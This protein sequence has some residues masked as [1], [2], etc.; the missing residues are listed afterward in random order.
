[1]KELFTM[2]VLT[3]AM[4]LVACSGNN[5]NNTE[6]NLNFDKT[7]PEIVVNTLAEKF[8]SG[9]D[10]AFTA[11]L[12]TV[13]N[14]LRAIIKKGDVEKACA[15]AK[16]IKDFLELNN[17]SDWLTITINDII[18]IDKLCREQ[19]I[20]QRAGYIFLNLPDHKNIDDV[21]KSVFSSSF[22]EV[23]EKAFAYE[24]K[25]EEEGYLDLEDVYYWYM[26]QDIMSDDGLQSISLQSADDKSAIVKVMY[27]NYDI[28]EHEMRLV[29]SDNQWYCDNWDDMKERLQEGMKDYE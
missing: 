7:T 24:K 14:E 29:Y 2:A 5:A 12:E 15:Y 3:A 22:G 25:L 11:A 1:M 18:A 28:S 17:Y 27:K 20:L 9:N 21:D 16:P 19:Q 13:Q 4:S 23:L 10:I 26:A 6:A 8:H